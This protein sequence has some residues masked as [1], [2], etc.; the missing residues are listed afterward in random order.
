MIN[1]ILIRIKVV[2]ML[3]S[4]LLTK[5]EFKIDSAPETT[6]PDKKFAYSVYLDLLLLIAELSGINTVNTQ[7]KSQFDIEDRLAATKLA[8]ALVNE[9]VLKNAIFKK[10]TN[11]EAL[12]PA[13]QHL[14]D[15]IARSTVY[16]DFKKKRKVSL[17][18]EIDMWDTIVKSIIVKDEEFQSIEKS[19]AGYS[20][21]GME[22]AINRVS[23][24]LKSYYGASAGYAQA[25]TDLEKSLDK[26]YDLYV[27][28]FGLIIDLTREQEVRIEN[29][30]VKFLATAEDKNPNLKFVEN[31]FAKALADCEP[32][33]DI[34]AANC[35]SWDTD[36]NLV[37]SLLEKITASDTYNEYMADAKRSFAK[38]CEFWRTIM[39]NIILPSEELA[40]TLEDKSVYWNDDIS[41]MGTFVLKT[42]KQSQNRDDNTVV[43]LPKYKD[44][45]DEKFGNQLFVDTV[46]NRELYRSYIDQYIKSDSWDPDRTAF[47]DFII[48]I[49]AIAELLNFPNIPLPVTLNE[50]VEIANTYSSPKSGQFVNG[51]LYNVVNYLRDNQLL[52]K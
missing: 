45:E 32:L 4:Y 36:I 27:G 51:I 38:D 12:L 8:R 1:R 13:V 26:A 24:T 37:N 9:E 35:I 5:S 47:M 22:L 16:K 48:M 14:H 3:Y 44:E 49:C 40:E 28:M 41:I 39:K 33:Q 31:Q 2:Q 30:K 10:S 29:A 46:K 52:I 50:Y 11:I 21:V 25:L 43:L 18:D 20:S 19:V 34:L 42:I 7:R 6:S 23:A 15:K 17:I